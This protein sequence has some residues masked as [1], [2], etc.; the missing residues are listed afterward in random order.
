MFVGW[1][2]RALLLPLIGFWHEKESAAAGKKAFLINRVGDAAF[3]LGLL[4]LFSVFGTLRF[5]EDQRSAAAL[6]AQES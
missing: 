3:L 1:G 2:R 5:T 6:H 4:L